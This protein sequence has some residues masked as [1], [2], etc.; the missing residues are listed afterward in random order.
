[1]HA[2]AVQPSFELLIGRELGNIHY[3]VSSVRTVVAIAARARNRTRDQAA[4]EAPVET[5]PGSP[6]SDLILQVRGLVE[7]LV[8]VNAEYAAGSRTGWGGSNSAH[9]G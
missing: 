6:F 5:D 1:M 2:A 7:I 8:V 4:V 9:L 3:R